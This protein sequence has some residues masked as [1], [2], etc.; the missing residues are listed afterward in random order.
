MSRLTFTLRKPSKDHTAGGRT[1]WS[2]YKVH[3]VLQ[4][5][6]DRLVLEWAVTASK[7]E[8]DGLEV[9]M[10]VEEQPAEALALPV[11]RLYEARV[12]TAWWRP[13]LTLIAN[14]LSLFQGIPGAEG[15]SLRLYLARA[16]R[17]LALHIAGDINEAIRLSPST[18]L[19]SPL[20]PF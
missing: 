7:G 1:S 3:G 9:R 10:D 16:D 4:L 6:A 17:P 11:E 19:P 5:D 20:P 8:V 13:H 14:D 15:G 12:H 2:T 18:P